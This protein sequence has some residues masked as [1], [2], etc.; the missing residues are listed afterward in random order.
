MYPTMKRLLAMAAIAIALGATAC[1]GGK[2]AQPTPG[3]QEPAA[4]LVN[5]PKSRVLKPA[6]RARDTV[7]QLNN[8]QNGTEQ[9]TDS[10][11]YDP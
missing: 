6:D 8:Q 1:G 2:A 11:A 9:Q 10:G 4:N 5:D 7:N 3:P